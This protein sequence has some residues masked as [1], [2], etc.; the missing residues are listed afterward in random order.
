M[1]KLANK[2]V[3][4]PGG[5]YYVRKN[6]SRVVASSWP[7]LL[8]KAG[9]ERDLVEEQVCSRLDGEWCQGDNGEAL[10]RRGRALGLMDIITMTKTLLQ[11]GRQGMELVEAPEAEKRARVCARC[12][13]NTPVSGCKGCFFRPVREAIK[14]F[15]GGRRTTM[16]EALHVCEA[17]GCSLEV[18]VWFPLGV[19]WKNM[20]KKVKDELH[21]DCWLR[22]AETEV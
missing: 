22:A 13:K 20:P 15:K 10:P 16:D 18:K 5:F 11:W 7:E 14:G 21:E 19:L 1:M 12:P 2:T 4:P 8:A 17:C 3:V 6:G 9:D